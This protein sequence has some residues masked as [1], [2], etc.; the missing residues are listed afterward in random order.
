MNVR[1]SRLTAVAALA[2]TGGLALSACGGSGGTAVGTASAASDAGGSGDATG[3]ISGAGASSAEAAQTAWTQNFGA[4]NAGATVTYTAVGSGK[5][6]EQFLNG[7]AAFAGS[8][9]A[10]KPE[11]IQESSTACQGGT[12]F[13]VP[14][15]ISPIAV[16]YKL[17]GVEDLQLSPATL[18][19]IFSGKITTWND[20]AIAADNPGVS[21]PDKPVVPVHRSDKSGTTGNFTDYLAQTAGDVWTAGTVEEWPTDG[22]QSG[23]GTSGLI[24]TVQ[25]GDGTIGY[26][27]A[28]KAGNLGVAKL[29][30]GDQY[31]APSEEGA[32]AAVENSP[33]AEGRADTDIAIQ[34]DRTQTESGAYTLVLVSYM[35]LCD[36]YK[37]AGT[38]DLVKAYA[39]YVVSEQ[40]Q[41]QAAEAAGSA[42]LS[43]ALRTDAQ[44]SI[45][46]I[47]AKA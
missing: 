41:Q 1:F 5:G 37:D 32:A 26:A 33:R 45:D 25:G 16:V 20:P 36:T 46:T 11:E 17:D 39:T 23:D 28:S 30:I 9:D 42:P 27:D 2:L 47:K 38:A 6:R 3:K 21:L 34:I 14:I 43:E 13:D 8:D 19:G 12:A 29:K 10:M 22:G 4:L 35:I 44:A 31:V 7:G 18:A 24:S 15:Y 40:G